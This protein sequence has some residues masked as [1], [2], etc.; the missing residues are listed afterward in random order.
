[1]NSKNFINEYLRNRGTS[2]QEFGSAEFAID[3]ANAIH[4]LDLMDDGTLKIS[5]IE[6]WKREGEKCKIDSLGGWHSSD[7]TVEAATLSARK[8]LLE[9]VHADELVTL[10]FV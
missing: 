6:V 7:I 10:Q 4:L 3:R 8:F 9:Q 1:M 5:G 2:L